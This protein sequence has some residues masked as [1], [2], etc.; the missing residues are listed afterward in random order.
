MNQLKIKSAISHLFIGGVIAATLASNTQAEQT[1]SNKL[2]LT[3][4]GS[5]RWLNLTV[6]WLVVMAQITKLVAIALR[7]CQIEQ[8]PKHLVAKKV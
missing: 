3:G 8:L 4:G 1:F 6:R 7:Q 5:R 2:L